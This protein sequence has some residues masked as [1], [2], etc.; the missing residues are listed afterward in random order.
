MANPYESPKPVGADRAPRRVWP[1][2]GAVFAPP[3][4]MSIYLSAVQSGA[5]YTTTMLVLALSVGSGLICLFCVSASWSTRVTVALYYVPISAWLMF[6]Y[7]FFFLH[8]AFGLSL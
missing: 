8:V 4:I 1:L 5:A 3:A 2:I 6:Y 7:P